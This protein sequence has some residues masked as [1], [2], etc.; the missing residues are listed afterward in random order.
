[1]SSLLILFIISFFIFFIQRKIWSIS[2]NVIFPMCTF[3]FYYW[4]LAGAWIFIL[5]QMTGE[6]GRKIN[7]TYYVYLEKVYPVKLDST[8]AQMIL[9]YG[10]FILFFQLTTLFI[11]RKTSK[12][13][14]VEIIQKSIYLHPAII[15]FTIL[16][17]ITIAFFIVRI[18]IY[19]A[20]YLEESVYMNV[21]KGL[22]PFYSFHQLFNLGACFL[23][24]I[25][26]AVW[27]KKDHS[28]S[29]VRVSSKIGGVFFIL[30]FILTNMW[31]VFLGNRHEILILGI[32]AFLYISYPKIERKQFISLA[33]LVTILGVNFVMTDPLRSLMPKILKPLQNEAF[34]KNSKIQKQIFNYIEI[35]TKF[36][37]KSVKDNKVKNEDELSSQAHEKNISHVYYNKSKLDKIKMAMGAVLFSNEMFSGQFSLYGSL[38]E[39]IPITFGH[40]VKSTFAIFIPKFLV[41]D[42]PETSYEYYSKKLKLDPNQGFTINHAT[43]WYLNFG[44]IGIAIGGIFWGLFISYLYIGTFLL[45]S[46]IKRKLSFLALL[47]V[48]SY[49][50][51][52]IRGGIDVMKV[53]VFEA[54]LI[55]IALVIFCHY[56]YQLFQTYFIKKEK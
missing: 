13:K 41:K 29:F 5:D 39:K 47:S 49:F 15:S 38:K 37:T 19:K 55:P 30:V 46:D 22:V 20:I 42:R 32:T 45:N 17:F 24:Y 31:L 48:A 6:I 43:D 40:S 35:E 28:S 36:L 52:I 23:S 8:Y 10:I 14:K 18:P 26:L 21:R 34:L 12:L 56:S 51:M 44:V 25:Y 33:I 1:M 3:I 53:I 4:S 27:L 9:Y 50:A 2:K 16:I 54:I 7:I 11:L